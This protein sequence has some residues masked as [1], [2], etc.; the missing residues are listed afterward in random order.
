[1]FSEPTQEYLKAAATRRPGAS[2]L[3]GQFKDSIT[4]S[5]IGSV[6]TLTKSLYPVE[7][8]PP[9]RLTPE[10]LSGFDMVV[11]P[12][13]DVL[14]EAQAKALRDYVNQG[15]VLLAT[16]KPGLVDERSETRSNFLLSDVLGVD[17]VEEET[18]YA[19]KDGP[20]IYFQSSGH[21]LS[22]IFGTSE[23]AIQGK[24]AGPS[25]NY[26][27]FIRVQGTAQSIFDY[28]LPYLVPDVDKHI[29]QTWD[30]APPGNERLPQAATIN[31]FGKGQALYVGVPL[32][33]CYQVDWI[34][35]WI[36]VL[37]TRLVPRP[38]VRVEGSRFLHTAFYRQGPKRLVVQMVNST[39]WTNHGLAA[40]LRDLQIVGQQKQ[41][42]ISAARQVWPKQE[43]L[44]F[45]TGPEWRVHI[46]EVSIYSIVQIELA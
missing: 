9:W 7:V 11:L 40:P 15:G 38:P 29:F 39:V 26:C 36:R 23:V 22:A 28:K 35:E 20:G 18:K 32:F 2:F 13:T 4:D 1:V 3:G 27:P 10:V 16:W 46:P 41:F 14:V 5:I 31:Q 6:E 8:L 42:A 25:G 44:T 30:P 37:V 19:G 43:R 17:F 34:Q 21:S 12:E 45:S 33:R 24:S